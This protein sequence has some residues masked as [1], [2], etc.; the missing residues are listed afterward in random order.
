MRLGHWFAVLGTLLLLA[1]CRVVKPVAGEKARD[2]EPRSA[3]ELLD[4]LKAQDAIGIR[5]YSAKADVSMKTDTEKRSFKAHVRVVRDS[6]AWLSIT[7]ALGIEVARALLTRDSL[8]LIDK[9]HDTYWIG[10]TTQAQ[11]KFGVQPSL[12]LLQEALLGLPIDLQVEE[13]YRSDREDGMYTLTGKERRKFIRAAEDISLGDTLPHD[14]DMRE[15]QLERT[16]RKAER[17]E[18]MVYKYWIDP[19]SMRVSRVLISDLAHDQQADVRYMEWKSVDGHS[20]PGLVILSLSAPGQTAFGTLYL[21]RIQLNGPLNLPFRIPE[22]F[23]PM[24]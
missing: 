13:K 7:P 3:N 20:I 11:A 15:K 5:Y 24:E 4:I 22:K 16:L 17:R 9:F 14:K 23:T 19:D 21:D 2:L 10:D 12:K 18:A 8:Q 1:G 6:A